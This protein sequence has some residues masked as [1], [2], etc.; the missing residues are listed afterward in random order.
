MEKILDGVRYVLKNDTEENWRKAVNFIPKKGE[1]IIYNKDSNHTYSRIKIGD[2]ST[3]VNDLPFT[4]IDN[5]AK[6]NEDN[7][8]TEKNTFNKGLKVSSE[9]ILQIGEATIEY[10][11]TYVQI[12]TK[13]PLSIN[14]TSTI[15]NDIDV[16]NAKI[17]KVGN[18]VEGTDAANKAY[19]DEK[20]KTA[21]KLA[22][23]RTINVSNNAIGTATSFDGS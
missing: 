1:P 21:E 19:V 12:N 8:F 7:I 17:A 13:G 6:L 3:K 14:T 11:E 16:H 18:P 9:Q 4:D 23:P 20:S 5:V 15:V 2:G 10:P 22:T